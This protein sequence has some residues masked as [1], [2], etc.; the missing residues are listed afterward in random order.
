MNT[1]IA[2]YLLGV[3]SMAVILGSLGLVAVTLRRL[4]FPDWTGALAR[5]AELVIALATLI[6]TLQLLGAVGL[7][8][9]LP[10]V[11]AVLLIAAAVGWAVGIRRKRA[12]SRGVETRL[13][14]HRQGTGTDD[15]GAE[16]ARRGDR[17]R[18]VGL[19]DA[20]E[21]RRRDSHL[22]LRLLPP[23]LG[24]DV[25]PDGPDH[26]AAVRHPVHA[27]VLSGERGAAARARDPRAHARHTFAG[28]EL[29][30]VR[31]D[32]AGRV[33]HRSAAWTRADHDAGSDARA[34]DAD[35]RL[36]AGRERGQRCRRGR[37]VDGL[38]G[39]DRERRGAVRRHRAG[40]DRRRAWRSPSS[41]RCSDRCSRSR[42]A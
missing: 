22:R 36:L 12:P 28:A 10:I 37:P 17:H 16:P 6:T 11:V 3:V 20:P 34:G 25:R 15:H 1:T 30:V 33:V 31:S 26:D 8:R 23:A 40:R 7:F 29:P 35:D 21:L 5:L 9:L 14:G 27:A 19:A 4:Y 18:G 38:G 2:R 39:V 41:S 32:A 42:S 24:R 13:G